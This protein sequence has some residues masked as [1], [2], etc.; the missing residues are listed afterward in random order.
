MRLEAFDRRTPTLIC[1]ATVAQIDESQG[2]V[3]IHFD[4]WTESYDYWAPMDHG[5]LHPVGFMQANAEFIRNNG[6]DAQ[7]QP[8]N[9][10]M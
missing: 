8:P 6:L 3:L 1:V 7:L 2:T 4:G 5:H 9:G 10:E